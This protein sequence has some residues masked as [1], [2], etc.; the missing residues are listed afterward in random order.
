MI[1]KSFDLL[2]RSH[3]IRPHEP[4]SLYFIEVLKSNFVYW[5][6]Y[7]RIIYAFIYALFTEVDLKQ[8]KLVE[9]ENVHQQKTSLKENCV[10]LTKG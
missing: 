3:E 10:K 5:E 6:H 1:A 8:N 4:E 9:K 2:F 7:L